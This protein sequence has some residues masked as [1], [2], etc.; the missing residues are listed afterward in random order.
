LRPWLHPARAER[1]HRLL[2]LQARIPDAA[3]TLLLRGT[4]R[5]FVSATIGTVHADRDRFGV[6]RIQNALLPSAPPRIAT[7]KPMKDDRTLLV[8]RIA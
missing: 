8:A 2:A 6:A 3:H 7:G 5:V 1:P 4:M